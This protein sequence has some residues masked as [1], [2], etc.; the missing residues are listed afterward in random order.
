MWALPRSRTFNDVELPERPLMHG[1]LHLVLATEADRSRRAA[2]EQARVVA[3]VRR[4]LGRALA[5]VTRRAA[6]AHGIPPRGA[7]G[8]AA[9]LRG[10]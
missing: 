9:T 7:P 4:P 5:R 2:G 3:S 1:S 10:R 8:K 6:A